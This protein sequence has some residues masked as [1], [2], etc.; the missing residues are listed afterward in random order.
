MES[1]LESDLV[2][3]I[4]GYKS[5]GPGVQNEGE[6][7]DPDLDNGDILYIIYFRNRCIL[8]VSIYYYN[9]QNITWS[10]FSVLNGP[11]I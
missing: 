6:H 7:D 8:M 2:G 9:Y 5:G 3:G 1:S 11:R 10:A 4:T